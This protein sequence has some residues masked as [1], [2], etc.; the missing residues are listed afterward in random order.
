MAVIK[1]CARD[2]QRV[3]YR[4]RRSREPGDVVRLCRFIGDHGEYVVNEVIDT[5]LAE[6]K[7]FVQ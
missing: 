1:C 4:A 2:K 5:V 6:D 7:G 3:Q